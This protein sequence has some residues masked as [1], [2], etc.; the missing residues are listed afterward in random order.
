VEIVTELARALDRGAIDGRVA[1]AAER[2]FAAVAERTVA[3]PLRIPRGVRVATIGGA[4]LGGSGK[5][6]LAEACT[7]FIASAA[8][9]ALVGHAYGA[10]PRAPRV[11]RPD[12]DPRAVGDEALACAEALRGVAAAEVVVGP[13]RQ[14]AVDF[15]ASRGASVVV[16]DGP[17]Q[18]APERAHLALLAVH[19]GEPWG[20]RACP[21]RGN[22]RAPRA[23]LVAAV[24]AVVAVTDGLL[25]ATQWPRP[26]SSGAEGARVQKVTTA[27]TTDGAVEPR[28]LID[29]PGARARDGSRVSCAELR[30]M[31]VGLVTS[32]ARPRRVVDFLRA[33]G[34]FPA[35]AV[36][37]G[38]HR[39]A[40]ARRLRQH[41]AEAAQPLDAWLVTAKCAAHLP[42]DLDAPVLVLDLE[43][44][45]DAELARLVATRLMP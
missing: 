42:S 31:H 19:A 18:L 40:S 21:P 23:A 44:R 4:T 14:A 37:A 1:R 33:R 24:D 7:R 13:S 45:V 5:T 9:V 16:I 6:P 10:E 15:A 28:L 26:D 32:L 12:D 22:L 17:V 43:S 35:I 29:T 39:G 36:H 41:R 38:D 20:S 3:R 30:V 11:V 27:G 8:R 25:A 34:I 2:A